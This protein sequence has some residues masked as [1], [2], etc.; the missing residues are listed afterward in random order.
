MNIL[1][2]VNM[3]EKNRKGLFTATHEK[4]KEIIKHDYVDKY[5]VY[6]IQFCDAGLMKFLKKIKN[7]EIRN[8]GANHFEY[9]G[10]T[11]EKIYIKVGVF[12][13]IFEAL[14][15]DIL[16]FLPTLIKHK[17]AIKESDLISCHWGYPHGRI[18]FWMGKIYKK[19][20]IVTYHGSDVHTMPVKSSHIKRKVLCVMDNAYKNIFVSN[21]LHIDATKLGYDKP[22]YVITKNGV[23][24][25]KF[26]EITQREK[27]KIKNDLNLTGKVVGFVGNL[28]KIKRTDK[29]VEIFDNVSKNI[30]E[31]ISFIITGD[32]PLKQSMINDSKL[33]NLNIAFT[34]NVG[35]DEVRRLMNIMDI[36]VLPSI[37]EGFGCVIIEANACGTR[38]V[39][40]NVGGIEEAIQNKD[41]LVES[42]QDFEKRFAEKVC[43]VLNSDFEKEKLIKRVHSNFTWEIVAQ[44]EINVYK[45]ARYE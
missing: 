29:L 14:N 16:N 24:F 23:N 30:D 5:K 42:G 32:G 43:D 9:E 25:D 20:Y 4:L 26:Y 36:M 11:Y 10:I 45:G 8:K 37:N 17:N 34:G 13:K 3:N 35:V 39:A 44:D 2:L 19:K 27:N 22:N 41:M 40:S 6:S 18:A 12:N 33:K 15:L 21:K 31:E 38:V 28:N 7:K 1:Y